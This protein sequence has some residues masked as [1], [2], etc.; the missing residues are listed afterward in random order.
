MSFAASAAPRL[1]AAARPSFRWTMILIGKGQ[2]ILRSAASLPSVDPS[3]C[4]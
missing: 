2:S 4:A 3:R 1:R